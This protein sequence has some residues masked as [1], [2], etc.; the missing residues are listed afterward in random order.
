MAAVKY[1]RNPNGCRITNGTDCACLSTISLIDSV[2]L[3]STTPTSAN[4]STSSY[5]TT[6]APPRSAPSSEY[7]D[8]DDQPPST[9]PYTPSELARMRYS[10][11]T[12]MSWLLQSSTRPAMVIGGPIGIT[13]KDASAATTE[14]PGATG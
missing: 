11:A 6:W 14:M 13:A 5:E 4:P 9:T 8:P 7:F 12:G 10:N 2:P 1:S 3:T